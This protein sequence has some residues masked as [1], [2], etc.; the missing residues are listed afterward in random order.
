MQG[1]SIAAMY[2]TSRAPLLIRPASQSFRHVDSIRRHGHDV[3]GLLLEHGALLFRGF[4]IADVAGFDAFVDALE[5]PRLDYVYRST[6]RTSVGSKV[7]T[8]TEY[9]PALEIPLHNENA[10]QREWPLKLALCCLTPAAS[11]GE[12]PIADLERITASIG[13]RLMDVFERRGV[14]YIRHYRPFMDVP[15]QTVFQTEDKAQVAHYCAAHGIDHEWVDS[16]TLRT[17]QICQGVARHPQTKMRYFFN[18]AHL[19]HVSSLGPA[20]APLVKLYGDRLPRQACYGDGGEIP[21]EDL[22]LVREAF[23]REALTF[24]WQPDD[25]MLLDNMQFAH[26]RKPF[27]GARKVVVALLDSHSDDTPAKKVS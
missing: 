24:A 10:Y 12:T 27:S 25:V 26:G 1:L 8:A 18:Q 22:E 3:R 6:P 21:L 17:S 14:Q 7:F 19:F 9:P 2:P 15:W 13:S 23:R 16:K 4:A 20:A 5:M 11:G